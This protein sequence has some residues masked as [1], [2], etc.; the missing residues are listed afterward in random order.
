MMSITIITSSLLSP[1]SDP[2]I[3]ILSDLTQ[4][5]VDPPPPDPIRDVNVDGIIRPD[6]RRPRDKY[7]RPPL[8]L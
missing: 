5:P 3:Q 7:R 8:S 4:S 2:Q 1:I 6:R